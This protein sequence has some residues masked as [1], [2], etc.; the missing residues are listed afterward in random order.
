MSYSLIDKSVMLNILIFRIVI[1]LCNVF[2]FY[3]DN[4]LQLAKLEYDQNNFLRAQEICKELLVN[5]PFDVTNLVLLA[6][7]CFM[8]EQ[9]DEAL[10]YLLNAKD[11]NPT[12]A[13]VLNNIGSIFC[14]KSKPE[15]ALPFYFQAI[16]K[17]HNFIDGWI[18]YC[19][20][21]VNT[22]DKE[23]A[24]RA[25]LSILTYKPDL[26]K[27]RN[28]YGILLMSM[29]K[30]EESEYQYLITLKHAPDFPDAWN[31]LGVLYDKI[32]N[33]DKAIDCYENA[34]K[35]NFN[36]NTTKINLGRAYFKL[37][38]YQKGI[39]LFQE[40][41]QL[42]PGNISAVRHLASIY[43]DQGKIT[44]AIEV[45]KKFLEVQPDNL[46][47][48]IQ[49][50][51]KY[52]FDEENYQE[53]KKYFVKSYD[54]NPSNKNACKFLSK[55]YQALDESKLASEVSVQLGDI[56]LEENNLEGAKS[57]YLW[58]THLDPE[59]SGG[60]W[61]LGLTCYIMGHLDHAEFR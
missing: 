46:E 48:N 57:A 17:K 5:R 42:C 39:D 54:L 10:T 60:H 20:G 2:F 52:F 28:N 61:K 34:L 43:T 23:K 38:K 21:L 26:Y 56:C 19:E 37:K 16:N 40:V 8:C 14:K 59:N 1:T 25:Y 35:L 3:L 47:I 50:G 53:A 6:A 4:Q 45:Y 18:N 58:A 13:E 44:L 24:V 32:G 51:K 31:N 27:V 11:I 22:N 7:S 29:N 9:Y 55:V 12:C 41:F 15:E 30:L 36:V 33:T 49:L